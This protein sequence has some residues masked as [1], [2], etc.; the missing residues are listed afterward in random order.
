MGKLTGYNIY[1]N[2]A[3]DGDTRLGES[4]YA[5]TKAGA[6]RR[7]DQAFNA[8][9]KGNSVPLTVIAVDPDTGDVVAGRMEV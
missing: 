3:R 6:R 2:M 5:S 9:A 4:D 7:V 8:I 1:W